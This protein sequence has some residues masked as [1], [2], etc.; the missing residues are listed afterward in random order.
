MSH[1]DLDAVLDAA[2]LTR[3]LHHDDDEA[4]DVLLRHGD[5]EQ[6]ARALGRAL[7]AVLQVVIKCDGC[8]CQVLERWQADLRETTGQGGTP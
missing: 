8:V 2:A 5:H 7:T 3:A 1:A 4:V 6:I